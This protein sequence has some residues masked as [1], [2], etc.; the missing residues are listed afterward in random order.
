MRCQFLHSDSGGM[1][2]VNQ[3][4]IQVLDKL[5]ARKERQCIRKGNWCAHSDR[6]SCLLACKFHA[7]QLNVLYRTQYEIYKG[8]EVVYIQGVETFLRKCSCSVGQENAPAFMKA[9]ESFLFSEDPFRGPVFSQT[10]PIYTLTL[11]FLKLHFN[12][13]SSN[14]VF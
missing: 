7:E 13:A 1:T 6:L 5:H 4:N 9:Q 8:T 12:I 11:C 3:I 10:N 2:Y 14:L